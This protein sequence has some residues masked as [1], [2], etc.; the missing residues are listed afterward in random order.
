MATVQE[1]FQ[2]MDEGIKAN[3]D[4]LKAVGCLYQFTLTGDG[5]A[6]Y[7]VDLKDKL[8]VTEGPATG[9]QCTITMSAADFIAIV[10]GKL[11]PQVAFMSGKLKVSGDMS[12]AMK[13][14]QVFATMKG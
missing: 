7:T 10:D 9:A 13:L 11:N 8:C 4:K 14:Q 3:P 6:T 1:L 5:G 2:K 12:K